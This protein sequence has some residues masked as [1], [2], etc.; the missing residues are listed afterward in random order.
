M[1]VKFVLIAAKKLNM[2]DFVLHWLDFSVLS[3][4][5]SKNHKWS[6]KL[7]HKRHIWKSCVWLSRLDTGL[8]ELFSTSRAA[9]L[10]W[11]CWAAEPACLVFPCASW[12]I[13][14]ASRS[15]PAWSESF[16]LIWK[17]EK[18]G[19]D[20][21]TNSLRRWK[22]PTWR[23]KER[24]TSAFRS[25][26]AWCG[27]PNSRFT[28]WNSSSARLRARTKLTLY[29]WQFKTVLFM[30]YVTLGKREALKG[31][32]KVIATRRRQYLLFASG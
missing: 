18:Q 10:A 20:V 22:Q 16:S 7:G 21:I 9:R 13:S 4:Y 30:A 24:T 14:W 25:S 17:K 5:Q 26:V 32:V 31:E 2:Y 8:D 6:H 11:F 12:S 28:F 27:S 3:F 15:F 23:L 19:F 1:F 29:I